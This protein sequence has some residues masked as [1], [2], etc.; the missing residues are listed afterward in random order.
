MRGRVGIHGDG[1]V[2]RQIGEMGSID[3]AI[4]NRM[5][6]RRS[7]GHDEGVKSLEAREQQ[8]RK[9]KGKTGVGR[10]RSIYRSMGRRLGKD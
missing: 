10:K 3:A 1:V 8:R 2:A 7:S 9:K 5:R 4:G 6:H